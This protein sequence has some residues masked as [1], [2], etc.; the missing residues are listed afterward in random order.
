MPITARAR[1]S[2][3]YVGA[4]P[5]ATVATLHTNTPPATRRR[6][7]PTSPSQPAGPQASEYATMNRDWS[8]PPC[9]SEIARSARI[10]GNVAAAT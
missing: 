8:R 3:P 10:R 9:A 6:R 7:L 5:E 2:Q 1:R 4:R